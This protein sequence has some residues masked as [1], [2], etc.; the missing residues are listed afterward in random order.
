MRRQNQN[1]KTRAVLKTESENRTV[2][3]DCS[4]ETKTQIVNFLGC[5]KMKPED[6]G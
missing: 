5:G 2:T 6:K 4:K 3:E 1:P